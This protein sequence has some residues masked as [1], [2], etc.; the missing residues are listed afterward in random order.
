MAYGSDRLLAAALVLGPSGRTAADLSMSDRT[1][2]YALTRESTFFLRDSGRLIDQQI[3]NVT[4][5]LGRVGLR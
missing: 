3:K 1:K 4:A 2:Y 5:T